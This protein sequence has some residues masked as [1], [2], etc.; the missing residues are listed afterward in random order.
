MSVKCVYCEN[1]Y[2]EEEVFEHDDVVVIPEH[3]YCSESCYLSDND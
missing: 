3:W 2:D 1:E